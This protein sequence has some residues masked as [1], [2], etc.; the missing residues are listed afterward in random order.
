MLV[1]YDRIIFTLLL[2]A[3]LTNV[4]EASFTWYQEIW[5][6][7]AFPLVRQANKNMRLGCHLCHTIRRC[8]SGRDDLTGATFYVFLLLSYS[9][10]SPVLSES[11][12]WMKS[13]REN[14]T[15][16]II[17]KKFGWEH[18]ISTG[19]SL[20]MTA[21]GEV[22]EENCKLS[23]LWNCSTEFYIESGFVHRK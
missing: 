5:N 18:K 10:C 16:M 1:W 11:Q 22:S 12:I 14:S 2:A 19:T 8:F 17:K 23:R 13:W 6:V 3:A 9:I 15:R 20:G 4:A 7:S 21:W